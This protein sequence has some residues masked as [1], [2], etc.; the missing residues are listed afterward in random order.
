MTRAAVSITAPGTD[1]NCGV[2]SVINDFNSTADASG[3]YPVGTTTIIWTVTD[4]SGNTATC[5]Q[6]VTVE[7][8]EL[9][10]ITCPVDVAVN[11]D[12]DACEAVLAVVARPGDVGVELYARGFHQ[13]P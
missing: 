5:E 10:T 1:D 2:A 8:N 6:T 7:D 13:L 11:S 12:A 4:D 9:P 3:T